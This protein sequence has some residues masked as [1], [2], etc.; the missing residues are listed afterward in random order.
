MP[1]AKLG[2][3]VEAYHKQGWHAMHGRSTCELYNLASEVPGS[4]TKQATR[5]MRIFNSGVMLMS[6]AHRPL[7]AGWE[8]SKLEC[9]ILCDPLHHDPLQP[10]AAPCS[11]LQPLAALYTPSHTLTAPCSPLLPLTTLTG[12]TSSTSTR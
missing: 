10:L 7:L 1:C 11:P 2:A 9:R 4:C 5:Q 3:V 8:T 6:A 12:A